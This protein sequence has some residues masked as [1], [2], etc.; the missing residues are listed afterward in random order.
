MR[1][2]LLNPI[3]F[4]NSG[5]TPNYS[6]RFPNIDN[7]TQRYNWAPGVHPSMWYKE[8][9]TGQTMYLQFEQEAEESTDLNVY[10][11]NETTG[12]YAE[13]DTGSP[14]TGV[15]ISPVGWTGLP[16][17]QYTFTPSTDGT[18]YFQFDEG[19][20]I[21]DKFVVI[22]DSNLIK[23]LIKIKYSNSENDF[24]CIFSNDEYFNQYF[25]GQLV[26]GD[27]QNEI[28]GF[29]SDRGELIKL[30]ATP[31]RIVNLLLNEIHYTY[32]DHIN[33]IFSLD[34]IEVNGISY[35]NTEAPTKD[36]ISDSDLKNI[37]IKLIQTGNDYYYT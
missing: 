18:Y 31:I 33:T 7:I 36:D 2:P 6:T 30:Q 21:S 4:Y 23:N 5:Q 24:G 35:Q 8:W 28:S 1:C 29:Q 15:D 27:P 3:R 12:S 14:I 32:M 34:T 20:I 19:G 9:R 26:I 11:Y 16:I 25:T 13:L 17:Y 37:T 10:L 22:S